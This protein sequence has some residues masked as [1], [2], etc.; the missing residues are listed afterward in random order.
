MHQRLILHIGT[1][2]TGTTTLQRYLAK[3]RSRNLAEFGL[4]YPKTATKG[5]SR[6]TLLATSIRARRVEDGNIRIP[7]VQQ[8]ID[9]ISDEIVQSGAATAVVS[10]EGLS[11][12][13]PGF[14]AA[15][16]AFSRRFD[17][18][19]VLVLRRQDRFVESLHSQ[20]VRDRGE[21]RALA[22]FMATRQISAWLDYRRTLGYWE[23]EFGRSAVRVIHYEAA[24]LG[25][26]LL[27]TFF[28]VLSLPP[29][30]VEPTS[31]NRSPARESIEILRHINREAGLN[32]QSRPHRR[33][34]RSLLSI[35]R[36]LEI[37]SGLTTVLGT[38]SRRK[39][40]QAFDEGNAEIANRYLGRADGIL[41]AQD[42]LRV[43]PP[44]DDWQMPLG[45]LVSH[46]ARLAS[47]LATARSSSPRRRQ[48]HPRPTGDTGRKS[49]VRGDTAACNT[50]PG[51][52][53]R[54]RQTRGRRGT[55]RSKTRAD[56]GN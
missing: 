41:F 47:R 8:I 1:H 25:E 10:A 7:P 50:H 40:L 22:E 32:G 3:H 20:F 12:P 29:P 42:D 46:L 34:R 5:S 26:G 6:H 23:S 53:D 35:M 51:R 30:A 27:N 21:T 17:V 11:G 48:S 31:R 19:V 43:E 45:E 24:T 36:K 52:Q 49:K 14:A 4:C 33:Q 54:D 18:E 44:V 13:N 15:C 39:L 2:K 55:A 28:K 9:R 16:R 56:L 38:D 37:D